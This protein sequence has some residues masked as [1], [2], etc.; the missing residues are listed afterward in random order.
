MSAAPRPGALAR[1]RWVLLA[2][3]GFLTASAA[4]LVL[5]PGS[6]F[7]RRLDSLLTPGLLALALA[8]L[9][10][11]HAAAASHRARRFWNDLSL[12]AGA[13]LLAEVLLRVLSGDAPALAENL[14]LESP[15]VVYY[16]AFALAAER[17]PHH[18]DRQRVP[19]RRLW[20]ASAVFVVGLFVYFLILPIALGFDPYS[21]APGPY[22]LLYGT[23]DAFLTLRFL[24]LARSAP[25]GPWR[26][27]YS[28]VAVA[29]LATFANALLRRLVLPAAPALQGVADVVWYLPMLSLVLAGR[30]GLYAGA[31]PAAREGGPEPVAPPSG[32]AMLAAILIPLTHFGFYGFSDLLHPALE[33]QRELLMVA[34]L[35]IFGGVAV[36]QRRALER[37]GRALI[38]DRRRFEGSLRTSEQDLRLIIQRRSAREA[39]AAAETK[40]AE[41]FAL[42]PDAIG[43]STAADGRFLDVNPA[44]ERLTGYGKEE[45]IGRTSRQLGLWLRLEHR[46][47]VIGLLDR[48]GEVHDL[49]L[50]LRA[51]DGEVR[52]VLFSARPIDIDGEP[53]VIIVGHDISEEKQA[54]AGLR[55]QASLL[56]QAHDAICVLDAE[57]RLHYWNRGAERL[58]GW[59]AAEAL[60]RPASEVLFGGA[61]ERL[62]ALGRR[63]EAAGG[64]Q[65]EL[66]TV[67]ADGT[68]L[69]VLSSWS[70][71]VDDAGQDRDDDQTDDGAGSAVASSSSPHVLVIS[72]SL[73]G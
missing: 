65:G 28:L 15:F 3:A 24:V 45:V 44:F 22:Q 43:I 39:L 73:P 41:A 17:R 57:L 34:W 25:R 19:R 40:F 10:T 6:A 46:Q 54:L 72:A 26:G 32:Q 9:R 52:T 67:H 56:D 1:D 35:L 2:A 68:A 69:P 59:T 18:G 70:P 4:S 58:H 31:P 16:V 64:W 66:E 29:T 21:S 62:A 11:G 8:A 7:Y 63:I 53:C 50:P 49:E 27:V 5:D 60:A 71:L 12:V 30:V 55:R 23:L 51:R 38:A 33:D 20:P 37:R 48:E 14:I 42:S 13:W 47:R 61:G 36:V